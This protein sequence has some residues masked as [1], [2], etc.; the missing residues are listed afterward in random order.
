M[1][2]LPCAVEAKKECVQLGLIGFVWSKTEQKLVFAVFNR[3]QTKSTIFLSRPEA[4]RFGPCLMSS[5]L[6]VCAWLHD[7]ED[8]ITTSC[9]NRHLETGQAT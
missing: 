3:G 2:T 6:R 7:I 1:A 5:A 4:I 9:H 8:D